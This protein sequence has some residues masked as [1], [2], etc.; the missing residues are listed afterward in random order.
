[1]T[2]VSDR[3]SDAREQLL[4][5][6]RALPTDPGVYLFQDTSHKVIYV[7]KAANLRARVRSYFLR[8]SDGRQQTHFLVPRICEVDV[9]VE[10]HHKSAKC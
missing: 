9:V 3:E 10:S 6:V 8:G 2:P 7:G 5:R 1:M 4:E